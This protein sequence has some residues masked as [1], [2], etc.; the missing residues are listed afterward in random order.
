[1]LLLS[2]AGYQRSILPQSGQAL[3]LVR[4]SFAFLVLHNRIMVYAKNTRCNHLEYRVGGKEGSA[5]SR[6][7]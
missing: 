5:S 7:R 6:A 2:S 3:Y 4:C 1:M